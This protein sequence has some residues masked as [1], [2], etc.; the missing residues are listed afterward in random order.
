MQ[1]YNIDM[2][3]QEKKYTVANG[4]NNLVLLLCNV[5]KMGWVELLD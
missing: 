3:A 5:K 4:K 2:F 1:T